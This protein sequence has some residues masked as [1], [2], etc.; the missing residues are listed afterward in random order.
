MLNESTVL[1]TD[2]VQEAAHPLV[3][4]VSDYDPLI[5]LIGDAPLVLIGEASHGTH[6]FYRARSNHRG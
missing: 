1:L 5:T 6:E 4:E 2:V 3:G